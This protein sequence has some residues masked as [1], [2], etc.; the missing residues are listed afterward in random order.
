V[1]SADGPEYHVRADRAVSADDYYFEIRIDSLGSAKY[2]PS[3]LS[4]LPVCAL[5]TLT[6][7]QERVG[8]SDAAGDAAWLGPVLVRVPVTG[9]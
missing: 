8:G 4:Y 6:W 7:K 3:S 9:R 5:L 2:V 1:C